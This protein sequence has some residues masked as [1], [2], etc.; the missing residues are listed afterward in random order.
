M[1][2]IPGLLSEFLTFSMCVSPLGTVQRHCEQCLCGCAV[3]PAQEQKNSVLMKQMEKQL[4][5]S[6]SLTVRQ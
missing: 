3:G 5:N 2:Q 4:S 6:F 1:L